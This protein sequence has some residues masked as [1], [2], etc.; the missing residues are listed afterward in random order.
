MV[1]NAKEINFQCDDQFIEKDKKIILE[2][3]M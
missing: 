3:S 1:I 2:K